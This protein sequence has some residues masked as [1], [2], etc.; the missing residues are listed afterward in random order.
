MH[1]KK[2]STLYFYNDNDIQFIRQVT[3]YIEKSTSL[4][5]LRYSFIIYILS[6]RI[7]AIKFS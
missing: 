6:I 3:K 1:I 4:L 2:E 5:I 7:Y